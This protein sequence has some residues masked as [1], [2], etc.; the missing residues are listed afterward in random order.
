M[1]P[2]LL[3]CLVLCA[4]PAAAQVDAAV[5]TPI[6][7]RVVAPA[8]GERRVLPDGRHMLLK[9]GPASTGAAYL[10]LGAEDLPPGTGIPRH[11]H[12]LDEELLIVHRGELTV[13]LNDTAHVAPAGSVIYLPPRAWIAVSN[14][15]TETAT[16]MFVF[17]R[18]SVERCFQ[19][20]G[21][22]EGEASREQTAEERAEEARACQMTY[23][24]HRH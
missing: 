5:H 9:V 11:R 12:E 7:P 19:F 22:G 17:P 14:R 10:F 23:E 4:A 16:L 3:L 6:A 15:G 13:E 18:G 8:E 20:V 21:R 2:I 24:T 1:R